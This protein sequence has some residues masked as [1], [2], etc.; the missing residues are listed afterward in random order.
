[1]HQCGYCQPNTWWRAPGPKA[2]QQRRT[3]CNKHMKTRPSESVD[4]DDHDRENFSKS[5]KLIAGYGTMPYWPSE[6]TDAKCNR[7]ADDHSQPSFQNKRKLH[8]QQRSPLNQPDPGS[9]HPRASSQTCKS[10]RACNT[11]AFRNWSVHTNSIFWQPSCRPFCR[12]GC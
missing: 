6:A 4:A 12:M 11:Q 1:M 3:C 2:K 7:K 8:Q 9:F 5:E 10:Q